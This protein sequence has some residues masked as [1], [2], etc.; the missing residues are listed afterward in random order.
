MTR[1]RNRLHVSKLADF[2]VFCASKGWTLDDEQGYE[3]LRMRKGHD[4]LTVYR[5]DRTEAGK[6][7]VHLTC[8]GWSEKMLSRY[9]IA[10]ETI[11]D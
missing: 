11:N 10:K 6:P 3:A 5:R 7:L 9:L 4:L 1:S 2:A 8:W